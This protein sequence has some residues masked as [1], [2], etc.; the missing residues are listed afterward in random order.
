M[1]VAG[2]LVDDWI[3]RSF[4]SGSEALDDLVA[5]IAEALEEHAHVVLPLADV[6]VGEPVPESG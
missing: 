5:R 6:E 3:A 1:A 4:Q 2:D